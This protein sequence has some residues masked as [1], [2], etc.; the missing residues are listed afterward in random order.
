M[1]ST[2]IAMFESIQ[3]KSEGEG[4]DI[5]CAIEDYLSG[6]SNGKTNEGRTFIFGEYLITLRKVNYPLS[7]SMDIFHIIDSKAT[8]KTDYQK[9]LMC[10]FPE[11]IFK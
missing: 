7:I 5:M 3:G 11:R 6:K 10:G 2:V 4:N 9:M 1:I 8:R